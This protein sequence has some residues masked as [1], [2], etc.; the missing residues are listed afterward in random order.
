MNSKK[1]TAKSL[2]S[3]KVKTSLNAGKEMAKK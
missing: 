1:T 3:L 2:A